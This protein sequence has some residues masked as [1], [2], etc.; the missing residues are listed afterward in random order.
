MDEG[1]REREVRVGLWQSGREG[2]VSAGV[3]WKE[4]MGVMVSRG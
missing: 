2:V 3:V 1:V 4:R